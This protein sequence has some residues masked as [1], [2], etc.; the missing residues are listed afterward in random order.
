MYLHRRNAR[1]KGCLGPEINIAFGILNSSSRIYVILTIRQRQEWLEAN[2][3]EGILSDD[4]DGS[5]V[6]NFHRGN[7][8]SQGCLGPEINIAFGILNSSSR[9]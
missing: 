6:L 3:L 8:C 1:R 5:R 2:D 9:I 4:L 7:A